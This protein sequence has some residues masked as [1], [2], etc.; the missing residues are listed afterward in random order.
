MGCTR[1]KGLFCAN[2]VDCGVW[3]WVAVVTARLW[4][5]VAHSWHAA[6]RRLLR[7]RHLTSTQRM[8]Y[9]S[10]RRRVGADDLLNRLVCN[11]AVRFLSASGGMWG[12]LLPTRLSPYG[13]RARR[14]P[15]AMTA[16]GSV[17]GAGRIGA[18]SL[19]GLTWPPGRCRGWGVDGS[20]GRRRPIDEPY[21]SW[22]VRVKT[23]R[24]GDV[25]AQGRLPVRMRPA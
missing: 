8:G 6:N 13:N 9:L 1:R 11:Y 24:D 20:L 2:A 17:K 15:I 3:R 21:R 22:R 7:A 14:Q 12:A 10:G 4:G 19:R 5:G 23:E 18:F 25:E 16:P